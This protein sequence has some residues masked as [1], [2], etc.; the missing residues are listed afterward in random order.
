MQNYLVLVAL[1]SKINNNKMYSTLI[2]AL[3]TSFPISEGFEKQLL[4]RIETHN[5]KAGD[6]ILKAGEINNKLYFI[7]KGLVRSYY[8]TEHKTQKS[9]I[10]SWFYAEGGFLYVPHSF[11]NQKVSG[12]TIELIEDSEILYITHANLHDLYAKNAEA[13]QIGRI[14]TESYLVSFDERIRFLRL[15]SAESRVNAF[16]QKYPSIYSRAPKKHIATFLG[17]S[18]ET[19]SRVRKKG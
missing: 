5:G 4:K 14:I 3:K 19:L 2:E 9:D 18:A 8:L 11:I 10:T 12:E 13:N 1:R 16:K 6:T 17:L 7:R 15:I